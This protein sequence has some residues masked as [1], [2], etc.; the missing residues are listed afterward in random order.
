MPWTQLVKPLPV[1]L[2]TD[3]YFKLGFFLA[4]GDS[5]SMSDTVVSA[6]K[7]QEP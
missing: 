7:Q 1:Y 5:F 4:L 2:Q 3:A 6:G